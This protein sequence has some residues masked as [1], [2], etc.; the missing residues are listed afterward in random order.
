MAS[1]PVGTPIRNSLRYRRGRNLDDPL[2]RYLENDILP[3][4]RKEAR[5]IQKQ[6]VR[7]CISQK[8]LY[9]RSFSGPYLR[10]FTPREVARIL[11]ELHE[12]DY[13]SHSSGRSLVLRTRRAGCYWP[14]MATDANRQA[15]HCDQCQR[16]APV[17][18][19]PLENLKSI[20]SPWPFR[21]WGMDIVGKFPMAP[22]Q[23]VFLW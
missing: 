22:G 16:H 4:D 9:R 20:S 18:M 11:V 5:K 12:G 3:E 2:I 7:Y 21:K 17:S 1:H 6:V 8:K 19:L 15:K 14:T 10:C 13:E 23:K